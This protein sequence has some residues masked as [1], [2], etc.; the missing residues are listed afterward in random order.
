[1]K[2]IKI[3]P[4]IKIVFKPNPY[5]QAFADLAMG[6]NFSFGNSPDKVATVFIAGLVAKIVQTVCMVFRQ[7]LRDGV[8]SL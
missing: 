4:F 2:Y 6:K 7:N 3:F 1:M 5:I 8:A